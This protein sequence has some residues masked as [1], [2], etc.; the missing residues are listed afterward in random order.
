V[1]AVP[2][3]EL[4]EGLVPLELQAAATIAT[5]ASTA[6]AAK[7]SLGLHRCMCAPL[8]CRAGACVMPC[9]FLLRRSDYPYA[10]GPA[11]NIQGHPGPP[12]RTT[13]VGFA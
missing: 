2:L 8:S 11:R 13:E 10:R 9:Q 12:L 5:A 4:P 1:T 6:T 7:R 3:V